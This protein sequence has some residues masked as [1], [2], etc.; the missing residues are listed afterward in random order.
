MSMF[1]CEVAAPPSMARAPCRRVGCAPLPSCMRA[2]MHC[3]RANCLGGTC[4]GGT[5]LGGSRAVCSSRVVGAS[6]PA[7]AAVATPTGRDAESAQSSAMSPS[8]SVHALPPLLP[9]PLHVQEPRPLLPRPPRVGGLSWRPR[10][11]T[12]IA[13]AAVA[14]SAVAPPPAHS[15]HAPRSASPRRAALAARARRRWQSARW[16]A[17]TALC[18]ALVPRL[19]DARSIQRP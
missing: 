17:A 8:K 3:M 1:N 16:P 10:A 18:S 6:G 9:R 5:C 7:P 19:E 2:N 14:T 13:T 12:P 11:T 15:T 4:L